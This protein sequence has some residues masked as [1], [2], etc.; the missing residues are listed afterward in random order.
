MKLWRNWT[1]YALLV[2]KY[3][4]AAAVENIMMVPQN[5]KNRT[6]MIQQFS[7]RVYAPKELKA[8]SQRDIC[9]AMVVAA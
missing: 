8:G 3:N 4:G 5:I 2:E 7:F 6:H 9:A 1:R